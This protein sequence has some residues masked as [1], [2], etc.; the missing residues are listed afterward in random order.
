M[1]VKTF[2]YLRHDIERVRLDRLWNEITTLR[3]LPRTNHRDSR[4]AQLLMAA[5]YPDKYPA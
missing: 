2:E 1:V 5:K 4:I 3:K